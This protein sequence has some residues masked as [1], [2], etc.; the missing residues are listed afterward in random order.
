MS[1]ISIFSFSWLPW[2]STFFPQYLEYPL[3]F[4]LLLPLPP[5]IFHWHP[6]LG[7]TNYFWKKSPFYILTMWH[8]ETWQGIIDGAMKKSVYLPSKS[9]QGPW[10]RGWLEYTFYTFIYRMSLACSVCKQP[11]TEE[12]VIIFFRFI[13]SKSFIVSKIF[14]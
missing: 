6:Q 11:Y 4:K 9:T 5:E 8:L 2:K 14:I 7:V 10:E 1:R 13:S 3:E 12:E